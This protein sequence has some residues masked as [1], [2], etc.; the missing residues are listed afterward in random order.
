[1]IAKLWP[2]PYFAA[3]LMRMWGFCKKSFM[4]CT[5]LSIWQMLPASKRSDP[6]GFRLCKSSLVISLYSS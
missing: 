2:S 6:S 4:N 1:M 3:N 5:V